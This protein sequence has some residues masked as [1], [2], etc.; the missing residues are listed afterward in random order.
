[1]KVNHEKTIE[2]NNQLK[3]NVDEQQ[4]EIKHLKEQ[5]NKEDKDKVQEISGD[6]NP[7]KKN[8]YFCGICHQTFVVNFFLKNHN[9]EWPMI[10]CKSP[11]PL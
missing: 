1:M 11:F 10:Q 8:T 5:Y 7:L 3:L 6:R 9:M 2:V 4:D